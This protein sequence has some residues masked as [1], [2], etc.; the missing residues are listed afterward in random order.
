MKKN[1]WPSEA[2]HSTFT[3]SHSFAAAVVLR[4]LRLTP[5]KVADRIMMFENLGTG[6]S[7][8]SSSHARN[9]VKIRGSI[10]WPD[11]QL[12]SGCSDLL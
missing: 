7:W 9:D 11:L 4:F 2:N 6:V 5:M 3:D 12:F 1:S 10:K 8:V